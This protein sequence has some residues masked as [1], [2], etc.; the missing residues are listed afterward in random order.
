MMGMD[1][2]LG[3]PMLPWCGWVGLAGKAGGGRGTVKTVPFGYEGMY[4]MDLDSTC[5]QNGS[6]I[7]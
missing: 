1:W 5:I 3:G 6:V 7:K 4:H 2:F